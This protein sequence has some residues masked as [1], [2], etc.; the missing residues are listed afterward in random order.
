MHKKHTWIKQVIITES[1]QKKTN[2]LTENYDL[3]HDY[4][5]NVWVQSEQYLDKLL[6]ISELI[7]HI[8]LI[9]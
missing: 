1:L 3:S 7:M 6:S 4:K 2:T 5:Q 9:T 8:L